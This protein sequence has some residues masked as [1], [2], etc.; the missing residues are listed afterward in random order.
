MAIFLI[1]A[2]K[3]YTDIWHIHTH[4]FFTANL[5]IAI[6]INSALNHDGYY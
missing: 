5:F 4:Y 3:K 2:Y 1:K 6:E